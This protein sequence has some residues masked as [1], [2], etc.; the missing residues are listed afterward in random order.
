M[1]D[2]MDIEIDRLQQKYKE[3]LISKDDACAC[4]APVKEPL[5]CTVCG[6]K[7]AWAL[8]RLM[9]KCRMARDYPTP[10]EETKDD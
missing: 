10:I 6:R 8:S 1:R 5:T 9:A 2:P 4:D 7:A 3:R